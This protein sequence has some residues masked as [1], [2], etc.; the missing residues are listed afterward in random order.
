MRGMGEAVT[1]AWAGFGIKIEN[2]EETT[3]SLTIYISVPETSDHRDAHG[4]MMAGAH[5]AK[6]FKETMVESGVKHLTVKFRIRTGDN[7]T[8]AKR[9][10]AEIEMTKAIYGSQW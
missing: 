3:E 1:I 7:W 5:L 2:V 10:A 8:D 6:R 4:N 9:S